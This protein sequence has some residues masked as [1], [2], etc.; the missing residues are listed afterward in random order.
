MGNFGRYLHNNVKRGVIDFRLR[1][2]EESNGAASFYIHPYDQSGE[3]ADY[4]VIGELVINAVVDGVI[5][6]F[7]SALR[8]DCSEFGHVPNLSCPKCCTVQHGTM[9][10]P[11]YFVRKNGGRQPNT[12]NGTGEWWV[13]GVQTCFECGYQWEM[14]D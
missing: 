8:A 14:T 12:E 7:A 10:E 5:T 13:E 11:P 9:L 3:T 6:D 1:V 4:Y 2:R